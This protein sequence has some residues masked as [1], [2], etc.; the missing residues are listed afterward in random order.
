M[1]G[2]TFYP[3]NSGNQTVTIGWNTQTIDVMITVIG[4]AP[5]YYETTGCEGVIKAGTTCE[6]NWTLHDQFGNMLNLSVGG[7]ITWTAGGGVFTESNGTFFA[8]TVGNYVINMSSTIGLYHEIPIQIDHGKMASLEII[9][10][11]A[12]VTADEFVWLNTTR[13]DIM[14]NRLSLSLIHI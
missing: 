9:A 11:S 14:G 13:I 2:A 7:G 8:M 10:S 4:G 3:Y 1:S 12:F 5:V 6:L